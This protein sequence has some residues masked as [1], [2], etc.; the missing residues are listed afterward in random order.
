MERRVTIK[1]IA[2]EAGVSLGAAHY[3]LS[4]QPG[5]SEETRA[6]VLAIA[7]KRNYHAN[8]AAASL[9][10]KTIKI[11]VV[12]PDIAGV[13]RFYLSYYWEGQRS[14]FQSI[15]DY[16]IQIIEKSFRFG[17]NSL[18]ESWKSLEREDVQG[19]VCATGYMNERD[20]QT[21]KR[22]SENGVAVAL[23]GEDLPE[24]DAICCVQPNYDVIGR[25]IAELLSR[26]IPAK[27]SILVCAGQREIPSHYEVVQ[28]MQ[29][30]FAG[31]P[32]KKILCCYHGQGE[33]AAPFQES[34]EEAFEKDP[35][36]SACFSVTAR[37]SVILARA[38]QHSGRA[39]KLSAVGSDM[40]LE[41]VLLLKEGIFTNLLNKN[42]YSQAYMAARYLAEYLIRGTR[43]PQ[44][45]IYVGSE[46][47]FQSSLP[48]Y[49]EDGAN[50][51]FL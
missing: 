8:R 14:Y 28:G 16:N 7:Q 47:V 2:L 33:Q 15:R 31:Q 23:T 13:N 37:D 9:K 49:E 45:R 30:F 27:T 4:G 12:F 44:R 24:A 1:D 22:L 41:N 50:R 17:E 21:V 19:L 20:K 51:L 38:L 25:T 46:V 32:E 5:V 11:G 6:R 36:I 34:L 43:P 40:F 26:Q 42:P 10:R 48:L 35:E 29:A 3:A 18:T 39:G